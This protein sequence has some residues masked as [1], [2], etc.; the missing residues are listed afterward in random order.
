[1][2]PSNASLASTS[3]ANVFALLAGVLG[4]GLV[5]LT[6]LF[7]VP[8]EPTARVPCVPGFRGHSR[9][10][11]S[12]RSR[13]GRDT[14]Q[15]GRNGSC[16]PRTGERQ[17]R[18]IALVESA[19]TTAGAARFIREDFHFLSRYGRLFTGGVC[20]T[21]F[22]LHRGAGAAPLCTEPVLRRPAEQLARV[23]GNRVSGDSYHADL[24]VA[25]AGPC[26]AADVVVRGRVVECGRDDE[27]SRHS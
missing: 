23:G 12:G 2:A 24:Q 7:Q 9:C 17:I 5:F 20:A 13:G 26:A 1:M 6:P 14:G 3:P 27:W 8:D 18:N 15:P 10:R 4:V 25:A 16:V 21:R 22:R 11:I 19:A